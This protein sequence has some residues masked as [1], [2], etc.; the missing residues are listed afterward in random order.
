MEKKHL[1]VDT[2]PQW[3]VGPAGDRYRQ[4]LKDIV[5]YDMSSMT[6]DIH[7][8]SIEDTEERIRDLENRIQSILYDINDLSRLVAK[9]SPRD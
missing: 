3:P 7:P 5:K 6:T 4:F 2:N 8:L 1:D 9:L